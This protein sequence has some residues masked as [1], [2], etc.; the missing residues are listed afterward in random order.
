MP[1][2]SCFSGKA[3]FG[4]YRMARSAQAV[5]LNENNLFASLQFNQEFCSRNCQ[6]AYF[7]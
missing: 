5:L 6:C 2:L 1:N 7:N 3:S 4:D